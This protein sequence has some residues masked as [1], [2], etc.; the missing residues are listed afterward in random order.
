MN[1]PGNPP[2]EF[3]ADDGEYVAG[4][5]ALIVFPPLLMDIEYPLAE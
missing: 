4:D 1:S 2:E 5:V 3:D